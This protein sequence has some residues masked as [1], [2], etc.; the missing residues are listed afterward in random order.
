MSPHTT[1]PDSDAPVLSPGTITKAQVER[2]GAL[3]LSLAARHK[4]ASALG[5]KRP[6]APVSDALRISTEGLAQRLC[7]FHPQARRAAAGG[8]A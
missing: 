4:N 2:H 8:G 3:W 1:P 5:A 7:H 6:N